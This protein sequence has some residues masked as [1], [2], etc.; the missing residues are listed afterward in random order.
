MPLI[1]KPLDE[2][3]AYNGSSP[4]PSDIDKYWDESLCEMRNTERNTELKKAHFSFPG[5]E[6]YDM[7]FTGVKNARIHAKFIKPEHIEKPMP[8]I[9]FFHGYSG[10]APDWVYLMGFA[11]CGFCVAALDCRGQAGESEDTGGVLGNTLHGH[12]IRGLDSPDPKD[13]LFRHI[14]LDTAEL[15]DIV[16]ELPYVDEKRVMATGGSQGGGLTLACASLEPRICKAAPTYPFLSDYRRV[17]EMDLDIKAYIE[18]KEY[19]RSFDP[20]HERE[21]EIFMKLGYIDIQNITKRIKADIL[22]FTGLMD[23][24]CPPS[25]QFAAYNKITSNKRYIIYPDFGHEGL[26]DSTE[27][28]MEFFLGK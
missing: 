9:L 2:L 7:Y 13:L 4:C 23:D 14:F 8:A 11:A 5:Y 26:P 1:D 15:A 27:L 6:L 3:I 10:K 17:W 22:M 12:I 20:R 16:M 28:A 21:D 24:I 18:L 25:T 19:F